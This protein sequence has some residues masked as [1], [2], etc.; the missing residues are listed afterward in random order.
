[1][2]QWLPGEEA[3]DNLTEPHHWVHVYGMNQILCIINKW[4]INLLTPDRKFFNPITQVI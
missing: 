3:S 4:C 1:M 2:Y